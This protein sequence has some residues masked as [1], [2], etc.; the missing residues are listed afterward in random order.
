MQAQ[1]ASIAAAVADQGGVVIKE[2]AEIASGND[3]H[4]PGL[5]AALKHCR[6]TGASLIVSKLDRLSRAVAMIA[7]IMRSAEVNFVC[8]ECVGASPLELHMRAA[9]AQEERQ[10]IASRTREALAALKARG[11]KLG[12]ARKGH[13]AGREDRRQAGQ[14]AAVATAAANRREL[15][16]DTYREA[17]AVAKG[18]DGSSL[19]KIAAALDEANIST[20]RGSK[21]TAAAVSRMLAAVA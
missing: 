3:D 10:K 16:A 12:S 6:K 11:V 7:T 4:R 8:C 5:E 20:A 13:W 9:F 21:W 2:F 14:R 1:A 19:R 17:A 18:M 15:S